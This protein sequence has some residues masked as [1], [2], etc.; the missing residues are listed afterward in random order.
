MLK[1]HST[2]WQNQPTD[3]PFSVNGFNGTWSFSDHDLI[4]EPLRNFIVESFPKI[5]RFKRIPLEDINKLMNDV[6]EGPGSMAK[7]ERMLNELHAARYA[8]LQAEASGKE[9]GEV[10][11]LD[12]YG[13][14]EITTFRKDDNN[15]E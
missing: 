3:N 7:I 13:D 9:V 14:E 1:V 5:D 8:R 10:K 12:D 11:T 4:P 2:Y 6:W 15:E